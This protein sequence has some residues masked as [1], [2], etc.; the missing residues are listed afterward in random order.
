MKTCT[1]LLKVEPQPA[2]LLIKQIKEKYFDI[3]YPRNTNA[4]AQS[5]LTRN[6]M[7]VS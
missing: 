2:D 1:M 6:F 7:L 4:F 3:S 5:T